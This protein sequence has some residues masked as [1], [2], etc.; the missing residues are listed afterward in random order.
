MGIRIEMERV[1]LVAHATREVERRQRER[2][3]GKPEGERKKGGL[4][5]GSARQFCKP[6]AH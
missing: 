3:K 4:S 6:V 5:G 2:E 1:R